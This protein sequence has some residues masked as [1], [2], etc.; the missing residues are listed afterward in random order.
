MKNKTT[1]VVLNIFILFF[2]ISCGKN[3]ENNKIAKESNPKAAKRTSKILGTVLEIEME[4]FSTDS[5]SPCSKLP[6]WARVSVDS[7][8]GLG[9]GGPILKAGE[10]V[11]V[12]FEFTL[13]KTSDELFPNLQNK[14][15]GLKI[16]DKF[17]SAISSLFDQNNGSKGKTA[18]YVI[19]F[20]N[21]I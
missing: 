5:N 15:P 9:Q 10:I 13:S 18:L 19:R 20:Y 1:V 11:K 3:I 17:S 4:K 12:N 2:V 16:G 6:C 7:V 14:L 21:K 8:L